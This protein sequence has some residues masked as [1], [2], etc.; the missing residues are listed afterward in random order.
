[1][2]F[3][4]IHQRKNDKLKKG[5]VALASAEWNAFFSSK[6]NAIIASD[7]IFYMHYL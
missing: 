2:R 6:I 1:M 7:S 5:V 3:Y 4:D